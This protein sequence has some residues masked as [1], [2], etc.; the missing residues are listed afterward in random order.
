MAAISSANPPALRNVFRLIAIGLLAASVCASPAFA[1]VAEQTSSGMQISISPNANPQDAVPVTGEDAAQQQLLVQAVQMIKSGQSADAIAGPI[2]QVIAHY[3][4]GPGK[5]QG[6][7]HYCARDQLESFLYLADAAKDHQNAQVLPQVWADAYFEESSALT[8]LGRLEE[9]QGALHKALALSPM[10]SLY[11]SELAYT[12]EV[13]HDNDKALDLFQQ[14]E[15][16]AQFSPPDQ[17]NSELTHALRGE[18]YVL[19]ELHRLDEAE[20]M[21][22]KALK[23]DPSDQKSKNELQYIAQLRQKLGSEK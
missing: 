17:K 22:H 11:L 2:A 6:K 21:Y 20:A 15:G 19:T 4:D 13:Q 18:G 7:H 10:N 12:Y 1:Q 3:E 8:D 9:S 5:E 16:A 14:A 23:L